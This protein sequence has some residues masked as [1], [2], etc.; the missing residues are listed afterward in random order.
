MSNDAAGKLVET[1]VDPPALTFLSGSVDG[2]PG[3]IAF[4]AH[5][6]FGTTGFI[7]SRGSMFIVS[8]DPKRPGSPIQVF[9]MKRVPQGLIPFDPYQ[10]GSD[11]EIAPPAPPPMG[12]LAGG[13]A[14]QPCRTIRVAIDTDEELRGLWGGS[15]G[16]NQTIDYIGRLHASGDAVYRN[17]LNIKLQLTY[18]R[19]W[20][21][22]NCTNCPDGY[23]VEGG[24][25]PWESPDA[26]GTDG[27]L[28]EFVAYWLANEQG[29]ERDMAHYLSGKNI[30]GG[31]ARS[32]GGLC[33]Y[34]EAFCVSG[35]YGVWP[36]PNGGYTSNRPDNWDLIVYTHEKGHVFGAYHTHQQN[37]II[38]GCGLQY[39]DYVFP[40]ASNPSYVEGYGGTSEV[41]GTIMSYCHLCPGGLRNM[42]FK[43]HPQ[44]KLYMNYYINTLATC[45]YEG[46]GEGAAAVAD[47]FEFEI[48][49]TR[50]LDVLAN[51]VVASCG[52]IGII[53]WDAIGDRGDDEPETSGGMISWLPASDGNNQLG[54]D[55]LVYTPPAEYEGLDR[56][57]YTISDQFGNE[58]TITVQVLV[59]AN[60]IFSFPDI[61]TSVIE[62]DEITIDIQPVGYV[63]DTESVQL[64]ILGLDEN[65]DPLTPLPMELQGDDGGDPPNKI[66]TFG[67]TLPA[68]E[69]P[70]TLEWRAL[71]SSE[72][73]IQFQSNVVVTA[74]G[75]EVETFEGEDAELS[76]S[77]SGNIGSTEFGR[78]AIGTP[79]GLSDRNDPAND[80]DGSGRCFLTGPG[81]GNTDID[82]GCT[83]LTSPAFTSNFLTEC[84][85]AHWFHNGGGEDVGDVFTVE[86]SND[87]G[88]SW[89]LVEVFGPY[90][91][92][93]GGWIET[94]FRIADF[95]GPSTVNR[96]RFTACDSGN[97]SIVEAA[98]DKFSTGLCPDVVQVPGDLNGDMEVNGQ[99]LTIFLADWG[100][101]NNGLG[102]VNGDSVTD[103]YDL[104]LILSYWTS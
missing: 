2:E 38:D 100:N 82:G 8:S 33:D 24:G 14:Q 26:A 6:E 46:V 1:R 76:W 13:Q 7:E 69:C 54:R 95:V 64:Q 17:E 65:G 101:T 32:I 56:F 27:A 55:G 11:G 66:Y 21:T 23:V 4:I 102:D 97:G 41:I 49:E 83:I 93:N 58:S 45:N 103:G 62:G 92:A 61:P 88:Q 68:L 18:C 30:G 81:S 35:I 71:A 78:W 72:S 22:Q 48:D 60:V 42:S 104:T 59:G 19:V 37:P 86:V 96:V 50:I 34:A 79:D 39:C 15:G 80:Y 84:S 77:V 3:S 57:D 20:D 44:T 16:L 47:T 29:V 94:S 90:S 63:L 28:D 12:F 87:D 40:P 98:V 74:V 52:T 99:D 43:F 73:G 10:C 70:S 31:Q 53:D 51:D 75:F 5:S 36:Y 89:T 25:D 67:L 9:D 91:N 85:W